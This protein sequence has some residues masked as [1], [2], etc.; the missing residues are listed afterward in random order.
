MGSLWRPVVGADA[1]TLWAWLREHPVEG[2]VFSSALQEAE[3]HGFDLA[4]A[5]LCLLESVASEPLALATT[6]GVV[7][8]FAPERAAWPELA[9]FVQAH[10]PAAPVLLGQAPV[11][12]AVLAGLT[13]LPGP[14]KKDERLTV[15]T[16]R[17][18]DL[19]AR[20]AAPGFR[21]A[22]PADVH[23]VARQAAAMRAAELGFDPTAADPAGAL[24]G[25]AWQILQERVW[26]LEHEGAIVYQVQLGRQT[27]A[28]GVLEG[29]WTPPEHRGRGHG[30]RGWHAACAAVL[31]ACNG[32]LAVTREDNQPQLRIEERTGFKPQP[33]PQRVVVWASPAVS[34]EA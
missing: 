2:V 6:R 13:A 29:A 16:L 17:P 27:P 14:L 34:P 1:L 23:E 26:V 33:V 21:L 8:L 24:A 25:V 15:L 9:P 7:E 30:L 20:P 32:V 10:L 12:E 3:R 5:G 19:A 31:E 28:W 18:E 22:G 4:Q 11:V